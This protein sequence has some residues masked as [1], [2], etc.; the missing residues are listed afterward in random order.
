MGGIAARR[1]VVVN[2]SRF[3][4]RNTK[5]GLFLVA[6]PSLGS[7]YANGAAVLARM[8]R[9]AQADILRFSQSNQWLNDLDRE[10]LTLK[11]SKR[12]TITGKE[13]YEDEPLQI[14]KW[15][16]FRKQIV[17]PFS[18]ARYFGE[19][20]K[21]P[22]SDHISIAKPVDA[23]EIQH[24]QLV[25]FIREMWSLPAAIPLQSVKEAKEAL[26]A[27]NE[28]LETGRLTN[29][30][31]VAAFS[32]ALIETRRYIA[33]VN[34]GSARSRDAESRLSGLWYQAGM[35][36]LEYD[37]DLA[38]LCMIKSNG[39]VDEGVWDDPRYKDLP[40]K[41]NDMLQRLREIGGQTA[42][43]IVEGQCE[44]S[45]VDWRARVMLPPFAEPP[46]ITLSRPT[47]GTS[48]DPK[49]ESVTKDQFTI[50]ISQ[51]DQAGVWAWRAR[52]RLL[53]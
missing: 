51:A 4:E 47:G 45:T 8:L 20:Y 50:A 43:D 12:I 9:H 36:V 35:A 53:R 23:D 21:V 40:I 15:L 42:V 10:F 41:L 3:I 18:A 52:G 27:L 17:E 37:P 29:K 28:R 34:R 32:E 39:W 31:A 48:R 30:S 11:E 26:V 22:A 49:L 19:P 16:G 14:T 6:S 46:E 2:Q 1:F 44:V 33:E 13:L 24:R 5:I 25:R 38:N 7:S